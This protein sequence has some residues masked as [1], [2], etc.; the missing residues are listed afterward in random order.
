MISLARTKK[1]EQ[2]PSEFAWKEYDTEKAILIKKF[3]FGYFGDPA[4]YE[5]IL[6]QTE[7]GFFFIYTNGGDASPYKAEN[8]KSVS[9]K[10]AEEWLAK[11]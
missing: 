4:G 7:D 11:H 9:K 10:K 2:A 5:E 6:F 8:I 1:H 3:S